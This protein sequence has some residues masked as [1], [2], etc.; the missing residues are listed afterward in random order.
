MFA[1][2]LFILVTFLAPIPLLSQQLD[3][4]VTINTQ[5]L[6]S[7]AVDNLSD[8]VF[9]VKQYLNNT[10]WTKDDLGDNRIRCAFNIFI[11][12]SPSAGRYS[13][14]VFVGSQRR[15]WDLKTNRPTEKNSAMIRIFDDT[16]EFNYTRG[17]PLVR[18]EFRFDPLTSFLDFYAF[19][20]LGYDYD[21]YDAFSGTQN[22]QKAMNIFNLTRSAGSPKG[23]EFPGSGTY[24]RTRLIDELMS[25]KFKDVRQAVY[26]YHAEGL[27]R[28]S[29]DRDAALKNILLAVE[30]IGKVKKR[31]NEQSVS[32][33]TYFD[34]KYLE[35]CELFQGYSDPA[36]Y[37]RLAVVDP[38]HQKSYEEYRQKQDQ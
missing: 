33:K 23:W 4:D 10:Q 22:F 27:D 31:V 2:T 14:Q 36:V 17:V 24:N 20:I 30:S 19:L 13:A 5:Q 7:D 16:W 18:D 1:R 15:I 25:E 6:T 3:C 26:D 35:L 12:G 21:S 9:Q 29:T 34:T 28:L 38:S 8:F 37:A 32:I 11:K